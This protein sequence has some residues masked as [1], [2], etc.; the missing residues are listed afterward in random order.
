MNKEQRE[1]LR[2]DWEARVAEFKASGQTT[3]QW[4]AA[5]NIKPNKLRYWLRKFK[6]DEQS[7][8]SS[9]WLPVEVDNIHSNGHAVVIKMGKAVVEVKPGYDRE[10]LF[11]IL[12]TL[13][14]IC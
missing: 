11:D 5:N 12:R 8:G 1:Q 2:K 9:Q 13:S 10:M 14:A 6:S 3:T 7:S 4:C